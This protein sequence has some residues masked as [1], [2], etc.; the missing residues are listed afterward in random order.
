MKLNKILLSVFMLVGAVSASAQEAEVKTVYDFNPHWY[1]QGQIGGQYTLGE[2]KFSDLL[3]P[4]A[5]LSLGYQ[6][7]PEFALRL[8]AN[9]W[10]S[11]GGWDLSKT[12]KW[13]YNYVAPALD[14]VFNLSNAF[15]GYNPK[16]VLNV[17]AFIGGGA[18]V[19]WNN[20]EA[21]DASAA[22]AK[23][24]FPYSGQNLSYLWDGTKVRAFGRAG[25]GLDFRV[26]DRVSIGLEASANVLNDH[27]NSKKAHN[28][29]WYFNAL[30]G[31]KIALGKTYTERQIEPAKPAERIIE[32]IVEKPV[33]AEPVVQEKKDE[34]LRRDIFFLINS[35]KIRESEESKVKDIAD[36]LNQ[37]ADAKVAVTGY[38]DAG[39]GNNKIND[40]LAA[41]R[42]Q[43][44]VNMLRTKYNV[45]ESRITSDSKGAYIQPFAENDKNRVSICIAE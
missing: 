14:L 18:N 35:Y 24:E 12:Y 8:G 3:S 31:L 20:D 9:G 32:R 23:T 19:A 26:S 22:I 10:Q 43:S 39:T 40:R 28:A 15:A 4:N 34:A 27:Y 42:A 38:A 37:H 36:Y 44:V 21:A 45:P 33:P 17:T 16:R 41:Q 7:T 6:F 5:Q 2:I 25:L 13:K 30:A 1:I 11:R 29:D